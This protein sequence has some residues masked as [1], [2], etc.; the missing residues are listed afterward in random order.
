MANTSNCFN[1][2]TFSFDGKP[3]ELY[4]L[5][6]GWRD[7][8]EE[9][10]TGLN[11]EVIKSEFNMVRN[12]PNQYGAKYADVL[13]LE[14]DIF[15]QDGSP[16]D[17]RESRSI[18]NWL[19]T[20]TY[21]RFKVND[22]NTDNIYYKAICTSIHD[23][24]MGT[25]RGKHIVMTCD[26]PYAY[27]NETY[28]IIDATTSGDELWR[29]DN[30]SDNGVYYPYFTIECAE[31][32]TGAV[33][34]INQTDDKTMRIEM[35]NIEAINHHKLLRIDTQHMMIMDENDKLVPLYKI[36]WHITIDP[37]E[38]IQSS[39]FYWLRWLQGRNTIEIKGQTKATF[40]VSFMRKAGQLNEE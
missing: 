39:P 30:N 8:T 23:I 14:F 13:V 3:S 24:T 22:N 11:R 18:N 29:V 15:H 28:R 17:Y 16:F 38:A 12:V 32:Y 5:Y 25:F 20:E 7:A 4:G 34:I 33:E 31:D 26:S 1:G 9:W 36:G 19:T 6:M 35:D 10:E 27:A 21:K 37:S 40:T 2:F